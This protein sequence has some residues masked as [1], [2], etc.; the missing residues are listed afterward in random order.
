MSGSSPGVLRRTEA[1]YTGDALAA[2][3]A[4]TEPGFSFLKN[5]TSVDLLCSTTISQL[6]SMLMDSLCQVP[7]R[8][9]QIRQSRL[10]QHSVR[11]DPDSSPA[12]DA[13]LLCAED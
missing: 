4:L 11:M 10:P 13:M 6:A 7:K 8:T 9:A 12:V 2:R 5:N 3:V 1:N